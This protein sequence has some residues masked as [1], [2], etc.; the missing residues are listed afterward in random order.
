MSEALF[1]DFVP[2]TYKDWIEAARPSLRGSAIESLSKRSYEGIEID[3]LPQAAALAGVKHQHSLPGQFPFVRGTRAAGYRAR[4]WLIAA[5]LDISDPRAFNAALRDG[6]ENGLTA[7]T[8]PGQLSL[9]DT[10]D[11]RLALADIDLER[12][13]LIIHSGARAP[14]IFN[15]LGAALGDDALSQLR[16]CIG[17]DPL[18]QLATAG[19]MPAEAFDRLKAHAQTVAQRSPQLGSVAI[20]TAAYHDAGANAVQEL[21]LAIATGVACLR[22]LNDRELPVESVASK[23][24]FFLNI[25][26]NFFMEIAKFRAVKL[27][28]AI[29][30]R[31]LGAESEAQNMKIH[32]RSGRRNKSRLDAHVNLLRLATEALSAAIGGVDSISLSPY[33][34]L[35]GDSTAFSRRLSRNLQLILQEE[36]RLIELID[37]AGGAWH[38]EKLTDQLARAAWSHFQQIEADGGLVEALRSGSIQA[39]IKAVAARRQQDMACGDAILVG[40][41]RFVDPAPAPAIQPSRETANAHSAADAAGAQPLPPIRLAE[42]FEAQ[43]TQAGI[44]S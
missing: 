14:E 33:D 40:V 23:L 18:S 35:L 28:W 13:P 41:N 5:E 11:I 4:P 30:L 10:A 16:G 32:A 20:S 3:P 9:T 37:P 7:I 29:V 1:A 44:G 19:A 12:H 43:L 27:L 21:A 42:P 24:H 36:L 15:L 2:S 17:Y 39:D 38:V 6:L 25:G 31:A 8:I 26:E 34:Q 22:A